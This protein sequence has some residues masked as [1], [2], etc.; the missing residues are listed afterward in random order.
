MCKGVHL[1]QRGTIP[2]GVTD[3]LGGSCP[4]LPPLDTPLIMQQCSVFHSTVGIVACGY[5]MPGSDTRT[6]ARNFSIGVFSFFRG[7][8]LFFRGLFVVREG[9]TFYKLTKTPLIYMVS[10]FNLGGL[11]FCLGE[12]CPPNPPVTTGLSDI[13]VSSLKYTTSHC[14]HTLS[15][16]TS[17]NFRWQIKK[18]ISR[19][20][21]TRRQSAVLI[22]CESCITSSLLGQPKVNKVKIFGYH[23]RLQ[24]Y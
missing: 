15:Y 10:C 14:Q 12:L 11:E 13:G 2:G 23:E 9:L 3:V 5:A 22:L 8:F 18:I 20:A 4:K 19:Q 17:C 24:S 16:H 6:V 21:I 1:W 7:G